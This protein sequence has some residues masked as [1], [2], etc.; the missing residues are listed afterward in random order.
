MCFVPYEFAC[1]VRKSL[2]WICEVVLGMQSVRGCEVTVRFGLC[3]GERERRRKVWLL[4]SVL[5][6]VL[7]EVRNLL[8]RK[9]VKSGFLQ[10]L[11][12]LFA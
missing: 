1:L 3:D 10:A 8:V 6:V 9:K 7:W 5:K 2:A 11:F 4:F 12:N